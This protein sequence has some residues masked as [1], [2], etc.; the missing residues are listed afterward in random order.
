M[1]KRLALFIALLLVL[2]AALPVIA[3]CNTDKTV[4]NLKFI[5]P[6]T[7]YTEG[8]TIDYDS[9]KVEIT[10]EDQSKETKTV[11]EL[12]SLGATLT[13]ADLSKQG[14]TYYALSYKGT[15][16]R[17]DISVAAKN[18][19]VKDEVTVVLYYH[20]GKTN[21]VTITL[22]RNTALGD[23]LPANPTREG[24]TFEG[25]YTEETGG[26]KWEASSPV[27]G[28]TLNLH[29]QWK[30]IVKEKVTVTFHANDGSAEDALVTLHVNKG[31]AL[32]KLPADPAREGYAFAGWFTQAT[33]GSQWNLETT[34]DGTLDLYA[35]WTTDA[36]G[37][38]EPAQVTVVL[39]YHDNVTSDELVVV[40][41]GA[42]LGNKLPAEPTRVEHTFD[43]WY[44]EEQAGY[45]W[46]AESN[47]DG[48]IDLYA[49]WLEVGVEYVTVTLMF[50]D[51]K[52]DNLVLNNIIKGS[53]LGDL[54]P[55]DITRTNYEF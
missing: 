9:L 50:H 20:D 29:A 16:A 18:V 12:K 17:V 41:K 36:Q 51:D 6:K 52:T 54:L 2:T 35:Q 10:Y 5:D 3:A 14:N 39:H 1:R 11:K 24:Y 49:R 8:D 37:A 55:A 7:S 21:P 28:N 13:E 44:T 33:E 4:T 27:Q 34:V 19:D 43:G 23:K 31:T 25:W 38:A 45:K 46:T 30:L 32:A 42:A 26:T 48:N 40:D 15:T 22:D 53:T 47:V